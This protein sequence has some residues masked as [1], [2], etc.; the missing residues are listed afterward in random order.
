M[1]A[2]PG[3]PLEG[4]VEALPPLKVRQERWDFLSDKAEAEPPL[5]MRRENRSLVEL[6]RD[7][8]V[9]LLVHTG[10]SRCNF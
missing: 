8:A 10:M 5:R 9:F 1:V 6:C 4:Q 7:P 2:T 3:V